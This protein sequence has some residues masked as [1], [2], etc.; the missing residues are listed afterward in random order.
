MGEVMK[1]EINVLRVLAVL[2]LFMGFVA[3]ASQVSVMLY[4]NSYSYVVRTYDINS[5]GV[6]TI[7]ADEIKNP[8]LSSFSVFGSD[9]DMYLLS[10]HQVNMTRKVMKSLDDVLNE[11]VGQTIS[12]KITGDEEIKGKLVWYNNVYLGIDTNSSLKV[13]SQSQVVAI[14]LPKQ[15][16]YRDETYAEDVLSLFGMAH[17][18]KASIA[19]GY[20][21]TNL[22][23]S[24][25]YDLIP[26]DDKSARLV[27]YATISNNGDESYDNAD[28]T[29]TLIN[30]NFANLYYPI[31]SYGYDYKYASAEAGL[32][33]ASQG[34][35]GFQTV[36]QGGIWSYEADR[37]VSI[38][39]KSSKMLLLFDDEVSYLKKFVWDT[40]RGDKAYMTYNIT[41]S[42]DEILPAGTV[43]VLN[44]MQFV[45][46]D[47]V[48]MLASGDSAE[49]FVSDAPQFTVS[50]RILSD[51]TGGIFN[52]RT[53]HEV[54]VRLTVQNYDSQGQ[55][56]EIRDY[57][58]Q[59]SDFK[60][61]SSSVPPKYSDGNKI[62]WEVYVDADGSAQIEYVYSYTSRY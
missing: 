36:Q 9:V 29:L 51:E 44:G 2:A 49:L 7:S 18:D 37:K 46:Q 22:L 54:T 45:G 28:I 50:K 62:V 52:D 1:L 55:S 41:N 23:W 6:F 31:R 33:S 35:V 53:S 13:V 19:V 25:S 59:Y 58:P 34:S 61:K 24:I 26:K 10:Y 20:P 8:S 60:I 12:I 56:I 43:R 57:I 42:R 32:E 15:S 38:P 39:A 14:S 47:R 40:Y 17:H 48:G 16:M 11:S 3:S 27:Q 21:K 30:P 5:K 4:P